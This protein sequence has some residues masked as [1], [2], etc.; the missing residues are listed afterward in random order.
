MTFFLVLV[1]ITWR[2]YKIVWDPNRIIKWEFFKA[3]VAI[4]LCLSSTSGEA[5][6]LDEK[7]II[8]SCKGPMNKMYIWPHIQLRIIGGHRHCT[9]C[10]KVLRFL[11]F[12]SSV[13]IVF[14]IF[15]FTSKYYLFHHTNT[16][17]NHVLL[18]SR[19]LL[20]ETGWKQGSFFQQA[21]ADLTQEGAAPLSTE[22]KQGLVLWCVQWG[23][24]S[25]LQRLQNVNNFILCF[26]WPSVCM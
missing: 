10:F 20:W 1:R 16:A 25:M 17:Q 23:E 21:S 2:A 18:L 26:K 19:T 8:R 6:A 15:L 11:T 13:K 12:K 14:S 4:C 9:W 5:L 22:Q 7:T 24:I 3:N